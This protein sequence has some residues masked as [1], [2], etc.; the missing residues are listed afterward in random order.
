MAQ[1]VR[2]QTEDFASTK[3]NNPFFESAF[4]GATLFFFSRA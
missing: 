2:A 1:V 4:F 3:Q